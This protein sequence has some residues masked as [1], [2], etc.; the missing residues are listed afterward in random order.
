MKFSIKECVITFIVSLLISVSL[1]RTSWEAN[2]YPVFIGFM[3]LSCLLTLFVRNSI[4]SFLL[5]TAVG[6][7]ASFM[8]LE[9]VGMFY[10]IALFI[11]C[12]RAFTNNT[13]L[14]VCM[15]LS[16][17]GFLAS[18]VLCFK[19]LISNNTFIYFNIKDP[20][21]TL[22]MVKDYASHVILFIIFFALILIININ[23]KEYRYL[24]SEDSLDKLFKPFITVSYVWLLI[25]T[26]F[27]GIRYNFKA[28]FIPMIICFIYLVILKEPMINYCF[29]IFQKKLSSIRTT[30]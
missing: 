21:L 12:V 15:I 13:N 30:T 23:K 29:N 25:F 8:S 6:V 5:I 1:Y 2:Y 18:T 10:P 28:A 16:Q 19:S 4:I 22:R 9:Y 27:F 14:K 20:L 7:G 3:L 11:W 17:P 26:F 24:E